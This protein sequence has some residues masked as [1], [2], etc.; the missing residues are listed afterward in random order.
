[1]LTLEANRVN[2]WH[3]AYLGVFRYAE[4]ESAVCQAQKLTIRPL[5]EEIQNGRHKGQTAIFSLSNI[6]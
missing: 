3:T 1:M 4:S 2:L 5:I 6:S